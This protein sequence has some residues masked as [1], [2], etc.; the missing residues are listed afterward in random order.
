V[1]CTVEVVNPIAREPPRENGEQFDSLIES[2]FRR[3]RAPNCRAQLT[4]V[5]G[6]SGGTTFSRDCG[7][8]HAT[9]SVV[10]GLSVNYGTIL[11][12]VF[13]EC[14]HWDAATRKFSGQVSF[15]GELGAIRTQEENIGLSCSASTQPG[16]GIRG[17]SGV[18]VNAIGLVCDEP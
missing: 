2:R 16:S 6:G 13:V 7:A 10:S 9:G 4:S 17:R 8:G 11:N 15:A 18:L 1:C 5:A 12:D 3:P 14:K